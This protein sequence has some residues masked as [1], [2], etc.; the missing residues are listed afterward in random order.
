MSDDIREEF[1]DA[2]IGKGGIPLTKRTDGWARSAVKSWGTGAGARRWQAMHDRERRPEPS[3]P[4]FKCL[5]K[6]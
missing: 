1:E 3:L 2:Q 6:S 5:E 4:K